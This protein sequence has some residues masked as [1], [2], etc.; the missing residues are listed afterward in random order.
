MCRYGN[1]H[2]NCWRK[3]HR[4]FCGIVGM[5][6]FCVIPVGVGTKLEIY[7]REWQERGQIGGSLSYKTVIVCL[8][9]FSFITAAVITLTGS[10][11]CLYCKHV[12]VQIMICQ[13][14]VIVFTIPW[15]N[16]FDFGFRLGIG[17]DLLGRGLRCNQWLWGQDAVRIGMLYSGWVGLQT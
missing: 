3:F 11:F 7:P 1:W 2:I 13:L 4:E 8:L 14:K 12:C 5:D 6:M 15:K 10:A 16:N 9:K 17:L